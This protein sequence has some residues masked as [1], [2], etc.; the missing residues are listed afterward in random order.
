MMKRYVIGLD[1]GTDSARGLLVDAAT[2]KET[3]TAV[4]AYR[5]WGSGEYCNAEESRFRQHPLDYIEALDTILR[6]LREQAPEAFSEVAAIAVDTTSSTPCLVDGHMRPLSLREEF[7]DYPDAMFVLWKEHPAEREAA[8]INDLCR[9]G[10]TCY[11]MFSGSHYS[12]EGYWAKVTHIV[13]RN[14]RLAEEAYAAIEQCDFIPALLTGA[15]SMDKMRL[16]HCAAGSKAMWSERWGG[17]PPRGFFERLEPLTVKLAEHLPQSNYTSD[18]LFGT[19][20]AEMATRYGL[21]TDVRVAVGMIDAHA[22]AVGAGIRPGRMALNL[23]TSACHMAVMEP[24]RLGDRVIADVF[25]QVDGSIIP[26]LV[27]FETGMSAFGDLYAWLRRLLMFP[28]DNILRKSD[29]IDASTCEALR[30]ECE[31]KMLVELGRQAEAIELRDDSPFA[32]DWINGRRTPAPDQRLWGSI[33]G[34]TLS[35]GAADI[36]LALVEATA[37][38]TK[39]IIDHLA[40]NGVEIGELVAIGGISRKSPLTMQMLADVLGR[41]VDVSASTQACAMGSVIMASVA[42]GFHDSV[43]QAQQALCPPADRSYLPQEERHTLLMRRYEK[44]R[45]AA[46]FTEKLVNQEPYSK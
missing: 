21:P 40:A 20:S 24:E 10:D 9:C 8:E 44:Y 22:G 42:G 3:A 5:R 36:Y 35:T 28:I 2:G 33:M 13:R 26:S 30:K 12:S 14:P 46:A 43:E 4:A 32:T 17:Y 37:F 18:H 41:R 27:G 16:G 25:G 34:L 31:D 6:Q 39:A 15:D 7:A 11:S 23:G 19:V 1:Y 38:A 45:A 29:T